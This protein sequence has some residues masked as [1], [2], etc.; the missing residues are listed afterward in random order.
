MTTIASESIGPA[1]SI[2][3]NR[4]FRRLLRASSI[5]M[6]GSHVTAIAYPLLILRLTGSPFD[7]GCAVFA[8]TAP[9]MIAFIPAGALVDRWSPRRVMLVSE[10]GRG[11]AIGTVAATLAFG[12][13]MVPL[14]MAVAVIEGVLEVFSGL[15]ERRYVGSILGQDEVRSALV[16]IEARTH[17]VLVAGRPLGGLLFGLGSI[18]PF[19]TDAAS[20]VYSVAALFGIKDDKTTIRFPPSQ[21]AALKVSLIT[22]IRRGL[23][24]IRGDRFA[25]V[26]IISFA[27]GTLVFQALI[28][29]FLGEAHSRQLSALAIG[30]VLAASGVGGMLGSAAAARLLPRAGDFWMLIQTGI[31]FAGFS[32]LILPIGRHF[33]SIAGI[34]AVL[35]LTGAL[36]NIALDTH[37]MRNADQEMLARVTSVSRLASFA[38]CAVGP[39]MGGVLMQEFGAQLAMFFLFILTPIPLLLSAFTLPASRQQGSARRKPAMS[40]GSR[41]GR[42][43]NRDD[44]DAVPPIAEP[45]P[46]DRVLVAA[47][48]RL[49][50]PTAGSRRSNLK[51]RRWI[52]GFDGQAGQWSGRNWHGE[53]GVRL[54]APSVSGAGEGKSE[55]DEGQGNPAGSSIVLAASALS[56]GQPSNFGANSYKE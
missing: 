23:R 52:A 43:E 40:A 9:S 8:A 38:A 27:I 11:V 37:L 28:V 10:F 25:R 39:I 41:P 42:S 45:L 33:F 3:E 5:S 15:A 13:P 22:D 48:D 24:W 44:A 54:P 14:L 7:A 26:T 18:F 29:V 36:G 17:F 55:P 49:R 12:R 50:Q 51:L 35:G 32:F 31:W 16:R 1:L 53:R 47:D 4:T 2:A 34:M 20:F 21:E 46:A 56:E 30:M 19:L 6:L